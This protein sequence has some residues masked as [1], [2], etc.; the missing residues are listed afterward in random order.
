MASNSNSIKYLESSYL[1]EANKKFLQTLKTLTDI[2]IAI[3]ATTN[4]L[5]TVWVGKARN[6]FENQY[7][8][9][10]SKI[11]DIEDALDEMYD[12]MV[13]AE[14]TYA[15]VDDEIRQKIA[16]DGG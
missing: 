15:D 6:E 7:R 2:K 10:F 1:T 5:Y 14:A 13:N 16:M 3:E 4:V 9:L 8:Q 12:M 11:S